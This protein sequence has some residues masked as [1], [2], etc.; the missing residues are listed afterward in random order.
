MITEEQYKE[1]KKIVDEYE[2]QEFLDAQTQEMYCVSCQALE[3]HDCF[4]SDEEIIYCPFCGQEE[5]YHDENCK[6]AY[7]L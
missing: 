7:S 6:I 5:P 4:C 2:H 3:E 1:A